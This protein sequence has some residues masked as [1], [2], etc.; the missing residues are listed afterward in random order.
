MPRLAGSGGAPVTRMPPGS[1]EF[2]ASNVEN[3]GPAD[4]RLCIAIRSA[5]VAEKR[6]TNFAETVLNRVD[7]VVVMLSE[8]IVRN[9]GL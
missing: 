6:R 8:P 2:D 9:A 1:I 7:W 5:R 3:S 4:A